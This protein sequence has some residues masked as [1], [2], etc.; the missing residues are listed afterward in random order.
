MEDDSTF[1]V[2]SGGNMGPGGTRGIAMGPPRGGRRQLSEAGAPPTATAGALGVTTRPG[3]DADCTSWSE[4][5]MVEIAAKTKYRYEAVETCETAPS[6]PE[7]CKMKMG[8]TISLIGDASITSA[9]DP[10]E[11]LHLPFYAAVQRGP[12][13]LSGSKAS[14]WS[15]RPLPESPNEDQLSE[16]LGD[17]RRLAEA[18]PCQYNGDSCRNAA[19]ASGVPELQA[20]FADGAPTPTPQELTQLKKLFDKLS[21]D[22]A[23]R[24][25]TD[26]MEQQEQAQQQE[27]KE[28]AAKA[29]VQNQ[30]VEEE[31]QE[32]A[33]EA[34]EKARAAEAKATSLAAQAETARL[35]RVAA[36]N[37]RRQME[38]KREEEA[39]EVAAQAE[40]T[41]LRIE[42]EMEALAAQAAKVAAEVQRQADEAAR[43]SKSFFKSPAPRN[44]L[45]P[46][47]NK[48]SSFSI[49]NFGA[50]FRRLSNPGEKDAKL[51]QKLGQLQLF[52]VAVHPQEC[53]GQLAS[54]GPT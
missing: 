15:M 34:K 4:P 28:V 44:F 19:L 5:K 41:Q 11:V 52:L 33:T 7:D 38:Y 14:D 40:A 46:T 24:R 27:E 35:A 12:D 2:E 54:F 43:R 45:P 53:M 47:P 6:C 31:A 39:A 26:D 48:A 17:R 10:T 29:K 23:I 1:T 18:S 13:T 3:D 22:E 51:T 25:A 32:A 42:K 16:A 50:G 30:E 9:A 21:K 20:A 49:P 37:T 36:T 8:G